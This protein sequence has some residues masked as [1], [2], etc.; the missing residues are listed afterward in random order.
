MPSISTLFWASIPVILAAAIYQVGIPDAA[1]KLV[2]ELLFIK[3]IR[4]FFTTTHCYKT[5]N[6]LSSSLPR[7]ECFS[8]S[9]GKFSR[10]FVDETSFEITKEARSGH[11]IPGL[12]DGHGH[13]LQ[14][15]EL[16]HSANL[17]GTESMDEVKERLVEYRA[18][19]EDAGSSEQWLRGVGWDQAN[20]DG[21][22]PVTSDLEIGGSF[23]DLYVMLDR[24]DVHCIWVSQKVLSLL[25]SPL[26]S[27]PGG[28]IPAE[29]VFC[30]NAMD[31]VM[32]HYPKPTKER[33]TKW[34]KDAMWELNKLGVVGI[35]DAGVFP[36]EVKLYEEL[37]GDDDW[38]VRVYAMIE[39]ETRNTFCPT[40]AAKISATNGKLHVS[41]VKLFGDGALGSW[42]SAMI[43]PYSDKQTSSGSLLV[44]ATTLARLTHDWATAGYQVNIHAIGDLANRLAIDAFES[45]L[46]ALCPGLS[47]HEC[48]TKHRFR[49]EHAQIIHPDDQKR[50]AKIGIIPSIQPT[51]ATSDMPYAE[52]RLGRQRTETE[53]YR[54]R[55]LLPLN[56]VLGSDF[57]VEPANIFEGIYAAGTRRSPLTGL[58]ASGGTAGWYPSETITLED[59]LEG[60]TKNPAYASFLEGKAGV[61]EAGAYA[62]WVVLDEPLES[63]DYESI[64]KVKVRETWVAGK[65][66]Y[67]RPGPVDLPWKKD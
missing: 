16:L 59:A 67:K 57:P 43:E 31:L 35:H 49:I 30:D 46:K 25:P 38:N 18:A 41:S 19:H 65:R 45:A 37:V 6:T 51:H 26:P 33:K 5:V 17:F 61:I 58:D 8:V 20:F 3:I 39:C 48:Q 15:G 44:N 28:E 23:K 27:V 50:M 9:G 1:F 7:A 29:G 12:W 66:V 4:N 40:N 60:F 11:V 56:P 52:D 10:V 13:L 55:S 42:G 34:I 22:W 14:Y 54:M 47:P 2:P 36:L 21:M 63:L 53:A 62:D 24:V 64:R 32:K